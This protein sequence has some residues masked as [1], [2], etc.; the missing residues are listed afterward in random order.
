MPVQW[1]KA[2]PFIRE[3]YLELYPEYRNYTTG[4]ETLN[5]PKIN[6]HN[7]LDFILR[8][9]KD[10]CKKYKPEQL[11]LG[12]D[13]DY[14]AEEYFQNEAKMALRLANFISAFLQVCNSKLF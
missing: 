13:T 8:M 2:S 12:G 4:P 7:A 5:K 1:E 10:N 3:K 11:Q 14:G 6:V 9:N